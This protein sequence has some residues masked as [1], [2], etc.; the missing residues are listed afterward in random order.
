MLLWYFLTMILFLNILSSC[1]IEGFP[2]LWISLSFNLLC[3]LFHLSIYV[4]LRKTVQLWLLRWHN[5][6]IQWA[7]V[8]HTHCRSDIL[9]FFIG[10]RNF[11]LL[12][13]SFDTLSKLIIVLIA[14]CPLI[15][16]L[17]NKASH[18]D[19]N[20]VCCSS[21]ACWDSNLFLCIFFTAFLNK[22]LAVWLSI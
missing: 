13:F 18:T 12:H 21:C 7:W 14:S 19:L 22:L 9:R 2:N 6:W 10:L 1:Y 8:P 15:F 5:K 11:R 16:I 20:R 17:L 4:T 3:Y